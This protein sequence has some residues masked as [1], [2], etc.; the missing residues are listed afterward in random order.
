[1]IALKSKIGLKK[2][3]FLH[4]EK[5]SQEFLFLPVIS[6]RHQNFEP[7]LKEEKDTTTP[8]IMPFI[9]LRSSNS[10]RVMTYIFPKVA[11]GDIKSRTLEY[12]MNNRDNIYPQEPLTG[13]SKNGYDPLIPIVPSALDL[14][15]PTFELAV[16]RKYL[17]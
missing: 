11:L 7:A 1:M 13:D 9:P 4:V 12:P 10:K 14:Y 3:R 8:S 16:V 2:Q 17:T 5:K 6:G 15:T